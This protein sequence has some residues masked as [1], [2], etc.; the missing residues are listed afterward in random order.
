MVEDCL[1]TMTGRDE[2]QTAP[3]QISMSHKIRVNHCSIYDV[4]RA[5]I[6][7]SEGTFGGHIIENCDVFNTVLETSD[8]GSFNSWGRDRFWT[9]DTRQ[10]DVEVK[11]DRNFPKIDML[12]KNIIRNSRWR[13][14]HGWD[15]DLDDGSTWYEIHNN[16]LLSGG[17][18]M[19]EGYYRTATNN[20]II[21]NSLHPHVWYPESGDVFKHNIVFGAYRPAVMNYTLGPDE[22]WGQKLDSNLFATGEA[23]RLKFSQND[24]DAHSVSGAPLFADAAHGDYTV[25]EQSPAL[26]IGFRNFPMDQFGVKSERLKKLAK[27]PDIPLLITERSNESGKVFS[28]KEGKVKNIE[29]MGE[30]SAAG[31]PAMA[32]VA[33]LEV[34]ENTGIHSMNLRTGD[35]ILK[36]NG[37]DVANFDQLVK[38]FEKANQ[39][40][41]L[42]ITIFR[43]QKAEEIRVSL[44]N[45]SK[46]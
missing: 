12:D 17:L 10:T 45:P 18:K 5:G 40:E 25:S 22:K 27:T 1:I 31:L 32:G 33:V 7:I 11:K 28:W 36:C 9:P 15:I 37:Q 20:I 23:D 42:V 46:K 6:N 44:A 35:V 13:C 3:V 34:P 2:K 26:K 43:N 41:E 38:I 30:Q 29:T 16:V 4:P 24:C 8:H 19:R 14:D 39:E 21:N